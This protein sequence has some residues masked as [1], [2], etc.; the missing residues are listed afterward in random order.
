MPFWP[1][2]LQARGMNGAEIGLLT[3]VPVLGK[4]IFSPLFASLGDKLG[5]RK[6]LMLFFIGASFISFGLFYWV[7]GFIA[8]FMVSLLYGPTAVRLAPLP[9]APTMWASDVSSTRTHAPN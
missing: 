2:W 7:S 6:R 8:L 1:L 9:E 5:E 4:M 3:A